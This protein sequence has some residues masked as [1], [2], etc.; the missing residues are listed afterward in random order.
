MEQG[1]PVELDVRDDPS[2]FR[3]EGCV[4]PD[5]A[6]FIQYAGMQGARVFIHTEV[7]PAFEGK[8]VGGR[9]VQGS[10]DDLRARGLGV[11]PRCP[12]VKSWIERHP[13]Y[14]DLVREG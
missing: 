10:L 12:F 8:G 1:E 7:D 14:A 2:R 4:G 11:V 3:Y 13:E 5:L 9:L 6:G